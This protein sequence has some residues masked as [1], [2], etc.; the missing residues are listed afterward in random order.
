VPKYALLAA[1]EEAQRTSKKRKAK[2]PTAKKV[3]SKR[4]RCT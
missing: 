4:E 2:K 1:V 3:N